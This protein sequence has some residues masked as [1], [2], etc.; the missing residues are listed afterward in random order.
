MRTR[1]APGV[2]LVSGSFRRQYTLGMQ[3][4]GK[5]GR[6]EHSCSEANRETQEKSEIQ[7]GLF[8]TPLSL[9]HHRTACWQRH[10]QVQEV[11][12]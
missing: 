10:L 11:G 1:A 8:S 3:T 7:E 9:C 4:G 6:L 12:G 2:F 5:E